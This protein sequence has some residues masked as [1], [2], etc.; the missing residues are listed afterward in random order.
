MKLALS[1][2]SLG[3]LLYCLPIGCHGCITGK[4]VAAGTVDFLV[5][6]ACPFTG[7]EHFFQINTC[8]EEGMPD[9]ALETHVDI[10]AVTNSA[11][12]MRHV[13]M[14]CSVLGERYVVI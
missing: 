12:S 14:P 9:R 10:H 6:E 7:R 2:C 13:G 5:D 4:D 3:F 8:D 11:G 1:V